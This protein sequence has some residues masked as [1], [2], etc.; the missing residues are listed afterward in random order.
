MDSP[1]KR[2]SDSEDRT[3]GVCTRTQMCNLTQ[4]FQRV[5]L[6]LQWILIAC[7]VPNH[8]DFCGMYFKILSFSG[9]LNNLAMYHQR[10][11]CAQFGNFL[12][13]LKTSSAT[14][15][16]RFGGA[17][18]KLNEVMP[19]ESR[20]VRTQPFRDTGWFIWSLLIEENAK[21]LSH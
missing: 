6:L 12:I 9:R 16:F 13:V 5:T 2:V 7:R 4:E 1:G 15:V 3:E 10:S 8:L 14:P 18:V 17:V 11:A 20:R 21:P 19:F